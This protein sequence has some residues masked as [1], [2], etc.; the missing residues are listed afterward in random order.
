MKQLMTLAYLVKGDEV[1]LGYK[2]QGIGIGRYN[3]F[4]GKVEIGET[5]EEAA[6]RE[7]FEEANLT[8]HNLLKVGV[9]NLSWDSKKDIL[10]VHLFKS[11]NFS[12]E[13]EESEE[14]RPEW[15]DMNKVPLDKMWSDD[16]YW[17]PLFLQNKKFVG[18]FVF[19]KHDQVVQHDLE[20]L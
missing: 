2:K 12:G 7:I 11:T 3:G 10:E 17:W 4:G 1:L 13:V 16:T 19:D 20:E 6:Q 8:V 9:L 18:N 15:F 14:M 5:I